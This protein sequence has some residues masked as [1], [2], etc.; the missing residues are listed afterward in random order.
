VARHSK[1][2][3]SD[4]LFPQANNKDLQVGNFYTEN[5]LKLFQAL[6]KGIIP[7]KNLKQFYRKAG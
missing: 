5:Q 6:T 3:E 7:E 2:I 1:R 4:S